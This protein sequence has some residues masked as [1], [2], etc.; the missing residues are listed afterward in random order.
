MKHTAQQRKIRMKSQTFRI[1]SPT[2]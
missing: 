1:P 2:V